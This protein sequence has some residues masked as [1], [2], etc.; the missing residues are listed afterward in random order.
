MSIDELEHAN[1]ILTQFRKIGTVTG[2]MAKLGL[3][4]NLARAGLG[5]EAAQGRACIHHKPKP[6][7]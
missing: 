4:P 3:E 6:G 1:D 7:L 2:M 5:L